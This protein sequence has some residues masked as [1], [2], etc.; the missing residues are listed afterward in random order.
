MKQLF[1]NTIKKSVGAA[2]F[3]LRRKIE[4]VNQFEMEPGSL[5]VPKIWDWPFFQDL[6]GLQ[7]DTKGRQI[8]ILGSTN[9]IE[10]LREAFGKRD[11][12][13]HG[14]NWDWQTEV[15]LS[16]FPADM[17]IVVSE[18]PQTEQHWRV[19][20]RLRERYANRVI[21]I[22]ELVLPLTT[23]QEGQASF[24][25]CV[26]TM[27]TLSRYYTG[28]DFFGPLRELD[29]V[30]PLD[31]KRVIEFGPM[32]GAQTAGLIHLGA[33][34]VT[35]IEARAESFIKTLI[36]QYCLGWQNVR[37]VMDDFHN[38]DRNKY[39]EFDLAFAHGVYYHSLAP[40]LFFEN[41]MSLSKN[42]FI[43]GYTLI[44]GAGS[45]ETID[46]DGQTYR[47]RRIQISN[48]FNNAANEYAYHL[49]R[50]DLFKFFAERNYDITVI[51]DE[52]PNDPWG[53]W[54]LRFLATKKK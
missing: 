26:N 25:Y 45:N 11:S 36:A 7:L 32:E 24:T 48:T 18:L 49:D 47:V 22:Q 2:G 3:E 19:L 15:D 5:L 43:G 1:K 28:R 40:F 52:K 34:S 12:V 17:P 20:K 42:I 39:G 13:I 53:D 14:V 31:G 30:F 27:E 38:A 29:A 51:S 10:Y 46:Y 37:L 44:H 23:I 54:F 35:C 21:G 4:P 16:S 8:I 6:I 33:A 9:R 41:L 50:D